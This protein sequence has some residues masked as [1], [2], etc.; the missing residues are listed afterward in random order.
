MEVPTITN[1][2]SGFGDC[3]VKNAVLDRCISHVKN[4]LEAFSGDFLDKGLVQFCFLQLI[5]VCSSTHAISY[6]FK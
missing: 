6:S 4:E 5:L 1:V 3:Y 2:L